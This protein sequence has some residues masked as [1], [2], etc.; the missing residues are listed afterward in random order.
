MAANDEQHLPIAVHADPAELEAGERHTQVGA[1]PVRELVRLRTPSD[2]DRLALLRA[3][4]QHGVALE[5]QRRLSSSRFAEPR[6][7]LAT[8]TSPGF[9]AMSTVLLAS[10]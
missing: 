1:E 6:R 7:N 3:D 5:V 4:H 2:T 8:S 9:Q 10:R